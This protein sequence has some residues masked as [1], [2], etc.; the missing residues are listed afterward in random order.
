MEQR[1]DRIEEA[2][3]GGET[4]G[5]GTGGIGGGQ[6]PGAGIDTSLG[7]AD[8]GGEATR[9]ALGQEPAEAPGGVVPD[10]AVTGQSGGPETR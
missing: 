2:I 9:E 6:F 4:A 1:D 7:D 3:G 5:G 8:T 10:D